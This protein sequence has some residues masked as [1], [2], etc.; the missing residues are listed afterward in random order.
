MSGW[1]ESALATMRF[2]RELAGLVVTAARL[3][4]KIPPK[5]EAMTNANYPVLCNRVDN[6]IT[7]EFGAGE[8][9]LARAQDV[10]QDFLAPGERTALLV[11]SPSDHVRFTFAVRGSK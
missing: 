5:G 1:S 7:I 3:T 10:A 2:H 4:E 8:R 6:V 11:G 9:T